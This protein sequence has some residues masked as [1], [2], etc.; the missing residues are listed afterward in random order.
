MSHCAI[1]RPSTLEPEVRY[2]P[3]PEEDIHDTR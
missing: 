2:A 3:E 1:L